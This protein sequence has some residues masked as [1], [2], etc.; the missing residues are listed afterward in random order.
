[1]FI[2]VRIANMRNSTIN[3]HHIASVT[4]SNG[5][6][7]ISTINGEILTTDSYNT[8]QRKIKEAQAK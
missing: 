1:M 5:G 7:V 6:C 8:V 2:E 3:I 4:E